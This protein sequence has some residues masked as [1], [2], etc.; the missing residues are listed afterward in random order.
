MAVNDVEF[1][2]SEGLEGPS[3]EGATGKAYQKYQGEHCHG[4]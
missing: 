2:L 1:L 3:D 4:C